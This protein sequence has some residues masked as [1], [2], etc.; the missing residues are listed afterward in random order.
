MKT[1]IVIGGS[2]G[3]GMASAKGLSKNG[4]R[5]CITSRD[6]NKAKQ[7]LKEHKLP[8]D[9]YK[10]NA[11]DEKSVSDCISAAI[12]KYGSLDVVI[13]SVSAKLTNKKISDLQWH[14]FQEHMD[15][16]LKGFFAVVKS[17]WQQVL[18]KRKTKFIVMLS[19]ACIGKPPLGLSHY[20]AAKYSLMGFT[21]SMAVELSKYN[22]TFN[23]ISPGMVDTNL[24][25]GMPSKLAEI[26]AASNPMKRI[27]TPEDVAK[28]VVFL[29]SEESD[30]LNGVNILV[31]GGSVMM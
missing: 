12:K 28:V 19:E 5:I 26:V 31:N 13:Y 29:A 22:C 23:M 24:I 3:I 27:A 25:S 4:F 7:M 15:A 8:A 11:R 1:A 6:E 10:L 16:Q 21:K 20:V 9:L 18:A 17:M 30:Y 2:G 14:E